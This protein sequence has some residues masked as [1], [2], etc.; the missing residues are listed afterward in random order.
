MDRTPNIFFEYLTRTQQ[1]NERVSKKIKNELI[2]FEEFYP[3][4]R[5]HHMPKF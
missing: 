4:T 1:L 2:N 3:K 5:D